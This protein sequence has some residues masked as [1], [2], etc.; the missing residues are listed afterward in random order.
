MQI[1]KLTGLFILSFLASFMLFAWILPSNYGTSQ[2]IEIERPKE[3][4]FK[5]LKKL[6]DRKVWYTL[7]D[8]SIVSTIRVT[9]EGDKGSK[10]MWKNGEVEVVLADIKKME[11]RIKF[12]N[13]PINAGFTNY[14]LNNQAVETF[15]LQESAQKTTVT[16]AINGGPLDYPIGKVVNAAV[17]YKLYKEMEKKSY[18]IKRLHRKYENGGNSKRK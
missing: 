10:F 6:E 9:G 17:R 14:A 4:V 15:D 5:T 7:V 2:F 13:Y 11:N 16:W 18:E 12:I 8:S 1:L 3:I